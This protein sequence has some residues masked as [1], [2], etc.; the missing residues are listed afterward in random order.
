MIDHG[1][2]QQDGAAFGHWFVGDLANWAATRA[3]PMPACN[4]PL[5]QSKEMEIKWGIHPTGERRVDWASVSDQ[6]TLSLLVRGRFLLQFRTPEERDRITDLRLER[7]GDYA[8]W[9]HDIEHIWLAEQDS[10]I[11]TV[12]WRE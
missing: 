7:E 4:S 6:R 5:R 12:R 8:V 2:A 1:N 10:V 3:V 11:L 9:C